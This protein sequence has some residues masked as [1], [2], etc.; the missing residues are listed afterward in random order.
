MPRRRWRGGDH[1][2]EVGDVAARAVRVAR[3]REPA[4]DRAVVVGDEDGGIRVPAERAQVA[5]LLPDAA[6]AVRVEQPGLGLAA[7]RGA[8][9]DERR[10]V[11]R[12]RR[13]D[14]D[15]HPTTMPWPPR[16]GSPAAASVPSGRRS[17]GRDTAEVEVAARPAH[18]V[19]A[20]GRDVHQPALEVEHVAVDVQARPVDRLGDGRAAQDRVGDLGD[21]PGEP[22][23]AGAAEREPRTAVLEHERRRHHARQPLAGRLRGV[24]DDVELAEH[25]VQLG[26][27]AE[28]ARAGA[29]GRGEGGGVPRRVEHGD[30]GRPRDRE[31]RRRLVA[32]AERAGAVVERLGVASRSSAAATIG[33]AAG[34]RRRRQDVDRADPGAERLR[35]GDPVVREVLGELGDQLRDGVRARSADAFQRRDEVGRL[36]PLRDAVDPPPALVALQ[37]PAR[38]RCR[39]RCASVASSPRP[40]R[41]IAGLDELRP[42]HAAE[43]AMRL[44]EAGDEPRDGDRA[45]ADVVALR[46]VAEVDG[47]VL[48]L[49]ERPAS[50]RRRSSRAAVTSPSTQ[51]R[52]KPPPVGP[53][54]GP[55]ATAAAKAAAMQAST[56]LPPSSSTRAPASA[57]GRL[58]AAI[59]PC[60]KLR[61]KMLYGCR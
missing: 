34:G 23:R 53:V 4:D 52:R 24:A 10:R 47:D 25:V 60:M 6:P 39:K 5:A 21:R 19:P 49:A 38:I 50:A 8:E 11:L 17:T 18:A 30:V 56:A 3:D 22:N 1:Q 36:D 54:S 13:A 12:A 37:D 27:A 20:L 48:D 35:H 26:A 41:S 44:L 31:R 42:R 14:L 2:A 59:A 33:A 28:D 15:R 40:A 16:R 32:V 61:V 57:V 9:L 58:P 55:S 29:E 46:R 45:L 7:D 43:A 51:A